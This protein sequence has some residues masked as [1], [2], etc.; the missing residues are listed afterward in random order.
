MAASDAISGYDTTLSV[1]SNAIAEIISTN[2]SGM[3][4]DDIDITHMES[5]DGFRE[6]IPGLVDGGAL[7]VTLNYTKAQRAA[8]M[9]LWREVETYTVT[10][11]DG[12]TDVF[13]GYIN[14]FGQETPHD[15]KITCTASFKIS[16]KPVFT[17]ANGD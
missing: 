6:F 14:D 9:A 1:D 7:D 10:Y 16:G 11:P 3:S 17:P 15:D 2:I 12:S 13:D 8:L 4:G 5:P